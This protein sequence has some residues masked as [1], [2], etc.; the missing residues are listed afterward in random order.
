MKK[1]LVV[2]LIM[3][4][5]VQCTACGDAFKKKPSQPDETPHVT[6]QPTV[7]PSGSD[8]PYYASEW[9]QKLA[10]WWVYLESDADKESPIIYYFTT[11]GKVYT[12]PDAYYSSL[13]NN[14][15]FCCE[16]EL[17]EGKPVFIA[18]DEKGENPPE[19]CSIRVSDKD[20]MIIMKSD[21][22]TERFEKTTTEEAS[23][24]LSGSKY[25]YL[26]SAPRLGYICIA[27]ENT[28]ETTDANT[29]TLKV[30]EVIWVSHNDEALIK[31][32]GLENA[33]FD[34]DYEIVDTD[35]EY[36]LLT[37]FK[38]GTTTFSVID[39]NDNTAPQSVD[40]EEFIEQVE[41]RGEQGMLADYIAKEG[42]LTFIGEVYV[43]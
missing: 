29:F 10:G 22:S 11:E 2:F 42:C 35:S 34:D 36:Q 27:D 23:R 25:D 31:E 14:D 19:R 7:L 13:E 12:T 26:A 17:S 9:A 43:P 37:A 33:N 1:S 4:M 16:W 41:L 32:Y 39:W 28:G 38:D 18:I 15:V 30:N 3:V 20:E 24:F 21:G 40:W 5:L 6:A 8:A